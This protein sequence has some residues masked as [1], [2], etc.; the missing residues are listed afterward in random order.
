MARTSRYWGLPQLPKLRRRSSLGSGTGQGRM[1]NNPCRSACVVFSISG[2]PPV[3]PGLGR[4]LPGGGAPRLPELAATL[5]SNLF[6]NGPASGGPLPWQGGAGSPF[7]PGNAS[8][9]FAG[10]LPV[11]IGLP[12]AASGQGS[13]VPLPGSPAG[14]GN[15]VP[16]PGNSVGPGASGGNAPPMAGGPANTGGPF[17]ASM[18]APS[19]PTSP[20][21]PGATPA[22]NPS[23]NAPPGLG[24]TVTGHA[25]GL[26]G[27]VVR[28]LA[29]QAAAPQ[30]P[31][32]ATAQAASPA[33]GQTPAG[34]SVPG[35]AVPGQLAASQPGAAQ[36]PAGRPVPG[37]LAPGQPVPGQPSTGPVPKGQ[38]QAL[39]LVEDAHRGVAI[40]RQA[41]HADL[42]EERAR[43]AVRSRRRAAPP[44]PAAGSDRSSPCGSWPRWCRRHPAD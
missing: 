43:A 18:N 20:A 26:A 31:A 13:P 27:A 30:T 3:P 10:S 11:P 17:A 21:L 38:A 44:A 32:Q 9:P 7:M 34:N 6:R 5:T 37:Q 36:L 35:Q 40:E 22:A 1:P 33:S 28:A 24:G 15:P 2:G 42:G 16:L 8:P 19:T 23:N 12:P 39:R 41:L 14:P 4:L 25:V 29:G